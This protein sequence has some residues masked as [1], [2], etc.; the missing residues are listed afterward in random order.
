ME[1]YG[2]IGNMYTTALVGLNGSIDWFCYPHHDSP[3]VFA[4][5]LDQEKGGH[6]QI[7]PRAETVNSQQ[8]YWPETNILVTRFL[9]DC[10]FAEII[11]FMPVGLSQ[12]ERGYH[13]LV[14]KVRVIGGNMPFRLE[15]RPAFNYGL[16]AHRVELDCH[17]AILRSPH[18]NLALV[19][20]MPLDNDAQTLWTKFTHLALISAAWNLNQALET[21]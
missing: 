7:E 11:D 9:C 21:R 19:S 16:E 5:M 20:E 8:F 12:E 18:L 15:C 4:A 17:G 1:N 13:W 14:R 10:G 2:I 3:S 6:F